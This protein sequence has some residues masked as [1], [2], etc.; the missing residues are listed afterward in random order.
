MIT[1]GWSAARRGPS[2]S[3]PKWEQPSKADEQIPS[4]KPMEQRT[5]SESRLGG[6]SEFIV[7]C[8]SDAVRN[9]LLRDHSSVLK[10]ASDRAKLR[11]YSASEGTATLPQA[12]FDILGTLSCLSTQYVGR[13]MVYADIVPSTQDVLQDYFR[14]LP[15]GTVA[16]TGQ[17]SSGRGRRGSVW[18]SPV[19]ALAFSVNVTVPIKEPHRLTFVQYVAA[20]AAVECLTDSAYWSCVPLRIKW[21]NDLLVNGVKV[22]GVLCEASS[23]GDCFNVVVGVGI[24]ISNRHP[25]TCLNSAFIA[26]GGDPAKLITRDAFLAAYLNS[27][28]KL[29]DQFRRPRG[30]DELK[31]RYVS[32]WLH[33]NQEVRLESAGNRL[34]TVVG[35][36][37]NGYVRVRCHE[38]GKLFDL[39]PDVTSLD[40]GAGVMRVKPQGPRVPSSNN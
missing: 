10:R 24:N 16:V 26:H 9:R 6:E 31:E 33:A 25:T 29:Y 5:E 40:L 22:G 21:P 37:P 2:D 36:A 8:S 39:A 18:E 35:L 38:S 11:L 17:Q 34:A 7:Y 28:E 23:Q 14:G 3:K 32:A 4:S 20:L 15:A 19:H 1:S 12:T 13:I 30:L 27:F